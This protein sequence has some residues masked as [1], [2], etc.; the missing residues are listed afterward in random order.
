MQSTTS[1]PCHVSV[2][3]IAD[4]KIGSALEIGPDQIRNV[5]WAMLFQT[6]AEAEVHSKKFS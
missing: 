3:L 5:A 4:G 1:W 2:F 6:L